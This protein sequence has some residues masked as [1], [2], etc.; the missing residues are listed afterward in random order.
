MIEEIKTKLFE[1]SAEFLAGTCMKTPEECL[2]FVAEFQELPH[3]ITDELVEEFAHYLDKIE[4]KECDVC[5]WWG[6]PGEICE[7]EEEDERCDDC[8]NHPDDCTCEEEDD[9]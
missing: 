6:Y 7:C 9:D 2:R 3:E 4:Q 1:E 5:G 8:W